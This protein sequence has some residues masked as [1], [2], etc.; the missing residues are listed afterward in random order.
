[1][2]LVIIIDNEQQ[3]ASADRKEPAPEKFQEILR[4]KEGI[5]NGEQEHHDNTGQENE[6]DPLVVQ[7]PGFLFELFKMIHGRFSQAPCG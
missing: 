1:M 4:N 5:K 2:R 7:L 3:E 6:I